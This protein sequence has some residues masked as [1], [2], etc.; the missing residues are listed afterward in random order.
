LNKQ[1]K[2]SLLRAKIHLKSLN[3]GLNILLNLTENL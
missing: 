2:Q 1:I 3:N